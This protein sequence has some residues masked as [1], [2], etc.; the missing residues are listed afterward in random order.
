MAFYPMEHVERVKYLYDVED[1][2]LYN[3]FLSYI[4]P[5]NM[6]ATLSG[7]G[8]ETT[9]I[10]K[11]YSAKYTYSERNDD[12]YKS[13]SNPTKFD[14]LKVPLENKFMPS[15]TDI[16]ELKNISENAEILIDSRG[17]K[18]YHSRDLEFNRPK[19]SLTYK[20]RFPK[21]IV[22]LHNAV[23]MDLYIAS[24]NEK[25]NK[26]AYPAYL[27]GMQFSITNDSE[28]ILINANGYDSALRS[29]MDEII[30]ALNNITI[31]EKRFS[32]IMDS[33]IRG[34]ENKSLDAAYKI[35][36]RAGSSITQ[37]IFYSPQEKRSIIE[38]FS[39][40]DVKAFPDIIF[41]G[42]YLQGLAHGNISKK[43]ALSISSKLRNA[44]GYRSISES[45]FYSQERVQLNPGEKIMT[46]LQSKVNNSA[47]VSM[48]ELGGNSPENRVM[49]M[50]IDTFI[51]QPYNMELRT[52][53]QL[54]Y[55]VAGGAYARDNY[56]GL[57]FIIQSD[58]YTA[59]VVEDR[60]LLFLDDISNLLNDITPQEFET[61]KSAVRERINEKSTS[62]ADEG[63]RRFNT[64]FRLGNN[65][66]RDDQ[67]LSSLNSMTI[68]DMKSTLLHTLDSKSR[69]NI[70][71]L[72]YASQH[73]MSENK[74]PSFEDLHEWKKTRKFK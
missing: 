61:Y 52:N 51:G 2:K 1:P 70:S 15:S 38:S 57:Y 72:L 11:W 55:I 56:S 6:L 31:D 44:L 30:D 63:K 10:E 23:L 34:L 18:V 25:L 58:G 19:A 28:G 14:E 33:Q 41:N 69:K 46:I 12:F 39:L 66:M 74:N 13:L 43:D 17:I 4:R 50:M 40:R 5:N 59:D 26:V 42:V 16:K 20:I 73:E 27:A 7:K 67:S 32:V 71:V 65:H 3:E 8:I 60:S 53:Q 37:K 22:S 45:K 49:A 9:K 21:N 54:G 29:L 47:Y 64:A 35:A 36:R 48:Y 62:I 68:D 24:V